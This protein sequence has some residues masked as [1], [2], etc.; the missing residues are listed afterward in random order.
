MKKLCQRI[1]GNLVLIYL[2]PLN[3]V[4]L[5]I[6]CYYKFGAIINMNLMLL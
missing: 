2:H 4:L 3:L 5:L 1:L 6:W